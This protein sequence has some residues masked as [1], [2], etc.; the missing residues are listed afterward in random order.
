[1]SVST[2]G[3]RLCW[4]VT[5]CLKRRHATTSYFL[6]TGSGGGGGS[7]PESMRPRI[8]STSGTNH[9]E[10]LRCIGH[11]YSLSSVQWSNMLGNLFL[12]NIRTAYGVLDISV[13]RAALSIHVLP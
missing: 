4:P 7:G 5:E 10:L 8:L 3:I 13:L 9:G 2:W 11:R 12:Q 1:M 6:C